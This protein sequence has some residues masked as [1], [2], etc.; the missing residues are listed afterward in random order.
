MLGKNRLP[1]L[2]ISTT[3]LQL[4]KNIAKDEETRV[5]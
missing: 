1:V 3:Q 5:S 2:L 4:G